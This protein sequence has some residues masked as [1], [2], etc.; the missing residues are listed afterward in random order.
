MKTEPPTVAHTAI[1]SRLRRNIL[2]TFYLPSLATE[3]FI[4]VQRSRR[5]NHVSD[6][7]NRG[8]QSLG[9]VPSKSSG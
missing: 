2:E 3:A 9:H 5:K 7:R 1:A 4:E 8:S 6:V